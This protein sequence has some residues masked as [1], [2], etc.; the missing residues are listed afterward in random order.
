MPLP[1]LT[2]STSGTTSNGVTLAV[3]AP[4]GTDAV[5]STYPG[6]T[7][8]TIRQHPLVLNLLEVAKRGVNVS[9]LVDLVGD[10]TWLV[11]IAADKPTTPVYTARWKQDMDATRTLSG[12]LKYTRKKR[13]GTALVLAMAGHGAGYLPEI[14]TSQLTTEEIT[15]DGTNE[16]LIRGSSGT[17]QKP[18]GAPLLPMGCPLLP[19]GCPL[20]PVNHMPLSTWGLGQALKDTLADGGLKI[21]VL[22]LDNCF[23]MS[24]ELMHT[25]SPY[26]DCAASYLNYNFFTAGSAYVQVFENL[27]LAG[28]ASTLQMAT[29]FAQGN[30]DQLAMAV[31]PRCPTVGSA[32]LLSR[33]PL[34]AT[35][36]DA[37][38]QA[39]TAAL[40]AAAP[41]QRPAVVD[42]IRVALSHAQKFDT[43]GT[44]SL[45]STD[46]LTDIYSLANALRNFDGNG[47]PVQTAAVN[48]AAAL[49]AIKVYG[50]KGQP[51]PEPAVTW[52]FSQ[53]TLAMNILCPDPALR[54]LWDWRSPY[55]LKTVTDAVQPQ[56]IDFLRNTAWVRFIVE[57]H[58]DVPF[59]GILPAAIPD[60]P[61]FK[62]KT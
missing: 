29:W 30:R 58:R 55:Y 6:T 53:P 2:F 60:Y 19:M 33:L 49:G 26:V 40:T 25:I 44:M 31:P 52:D 12:F 62:K 61:I 22:H 3:Y 7:P 27:K 50:E 21:A 5:L 37:L 10:D 56:L 14:D 59:I 15:Q 54:G 28:T 24:V 8:L 35:R 38:A 46:E 16:W 9:A 23:N 1:Q 20:L 47:Q 11:E 42:K 48:L 41:A 17:P 39:L 57:Y 34:I 45:D 36:I 18:G 4:F 43:Q 32:V 51:W 13:P